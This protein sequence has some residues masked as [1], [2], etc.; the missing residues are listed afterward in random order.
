MWYKLHLRILRSNLYIWIMTQY[1]KLNKK[2]LIKQYSKDLSYM[3]RQKY[4]ENL[5]KRTLILALLIL[6]FA[7]LAS[8]QTNQCNNPQA[9]I[10]VVVNIST[11]T[12]TR[13]VNNP[14]DRPITVCGFTITI[15]GTATANT[16]V[17]KTGTG[18]TCGT[19]TSTISG[20]YTGA[21]T[22]GVITVLQPLFPFGL[23]VK[24]DSL[25]ATTSQTGVVA[26]NLVY[27][28]N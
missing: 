28:Y 18:A 20:P 19:G 11:A 5:V 10:N 24:G 8:A 9:V 6:G 23:L 21:A 3:A 1:Y 16:L 2:N 22:A 26:G 25:C 13:L 27:A 15:V 17:F 7:Q 4:R 12:D 14:G